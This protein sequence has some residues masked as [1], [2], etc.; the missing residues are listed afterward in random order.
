MLLLG[1]T[2]FVCGFFGPIALNPEANQG[3][4]LGLFITGPGGALLGLILGALFKGL[5][6]HTQTKWFSLLGTCGVG[7]LV[8]LFF[9]F[10][11]PKV[12]GYVIEGPIASCAPPADRMHEAIFHWQQRIE[13]TPRAT[14]RAGWKDETPRML[15]DGGVVIEIA[16][17][18]Q[19]SLLEHRK[20][21][22]SGKLSVSAWRAPFEN[23][24]YFARFS[25]SDCRHYQGDVGLLYAV[26]GQT[27]EGW[28][29]TDLQHFL[30][31]A[32]ID[33]LPER[34]RSLMD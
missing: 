16:A 31:L 2:G 21:W 18:R 14:A 32:L 30:G 7:A 8:I 9:C 17:T 5:P 28:P 11:E 25:G 29:P 22:N 27:G 24:T 12:L 20:P 23:Q 3:P 34:Y 10:P 19:A 13:A 4:L 26:Y 15:Q 6:I 1:G 33:P